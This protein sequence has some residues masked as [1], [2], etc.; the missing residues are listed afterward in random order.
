MMPLHLHAALFL[1]LACS[2]QAQ[3]PVSAR[4]PAVE[5]SPADSRLRQIEAIYQQQ[6]R[7][8]HIPL[9]AKYLTDLQQSARLADS[10]A[11]QAEIQRVQA[12]ISAGGLVD[13]TAAA[14]ELNPTTPAPVAA[15]KSDPDRAKR[16][17]IILTPSLAQNI[18]PVPED[19]ASPVSATI[20]QL[21]WRID[22]LPAGTYDLVLHYASLA[23]EQEVVVTLDLGG[24]KLTQTLDARKATK[25][26]QTFRL[27]RLGQI[28]LEKEVAGSPLVLTAGSAEAPTL[29]VRNLVIARTKKVD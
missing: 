6:L 5:A 10:P 12:I 28:T 22:T 4:S 27:L 29:I 23:P 16:S 19:S 17:P 26:S 3:A 25:D 20:G 15:A 1:V 21:T 14:Q 13:L 7:A 8:R 18:Q 11:L 9:L 24:Q 2:L